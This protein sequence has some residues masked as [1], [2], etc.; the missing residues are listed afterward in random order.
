MAKRCFSHTLFLLLYHKKEFSGYNGGKYPYFKY[1][2]ILYTPPTEYM[3]LIP[4]NYFKLSKLLISQKF[5]LKK[6]SI[7]SFSIGFSYDLSQNF[8]YNNM[9]AITDF[10]FALTKELSLQDSFS[11]MFSL[12]AKINF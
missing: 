1:E 10:D 6:S 3:H 11:H 4:N 5:N 9:G 7:D 8:L 2:P 12:M